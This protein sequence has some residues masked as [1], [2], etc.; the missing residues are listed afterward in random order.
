M[1]PIHGVSLFYK[2]PCFGVT[3]QQVAV[4]NYRSRR[5]QDRRAS[6]RSRQAIEPTGRWAKAV[7]EGSHAG[8]TAKGGLFVVSIAASIFAFTWADDETRPEREAGKA[9]Q[10]P[11]SP[12][13]WTQTLKECSHL[14][15]ANAALRV[16][17]NDWVERYFLEC[18]IQW[19]V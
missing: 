4:Y 2:C 13:D 18:L 9:I 19:L 12:P 6:R 14:L 17:K 16:F 10:R 3:V 7:S 1:T 11:H 5:S 8:G 15:F